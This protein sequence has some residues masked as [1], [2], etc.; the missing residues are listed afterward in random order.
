[1]VS[2]TDMVEPTP[3]KGWLERFGVTLPKLAGL[4]PCHKNFLSDVKLGK[5]VPSTRLIATIHRVTWQYEKDLGIAEPRGIE[6]GT[7]FPE[8]ASGTELQRVGA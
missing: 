2:P 3:L 8:I 7:W 1:M 4:I 6:P 5:R